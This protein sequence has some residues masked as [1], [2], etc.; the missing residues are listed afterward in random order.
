MSVSVHLH[1]DAVSKW[2]PTACAT[3]LPVTVA[4]MSCHWTLLH[5]AH[6]VPSMCFSKGSFLVCLDVDTDTGGLTLNP[7]FFVDFGQEPEGPVL[8]HE[9]RYSLTPIQPAQVAKTIRNRTISWYFIIIIL[10]YR[11]SPALNSIQSLLVC[12]HPSFPLFQFPLTFKR[13]IKSH[14]PFA[15]IIRSSPYSPR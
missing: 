2:A 7:D 5:G 4:Q 11:Q 3:M 10:P 6:K 13:R 15:G 1:V 9:I 14:L 12:L 8:A